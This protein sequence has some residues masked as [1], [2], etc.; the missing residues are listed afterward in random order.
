MYFQR[1]NG[2]NGVRMN[3]LLTALRVESLKFRLAPVVWLTTLVMLVLVPLVTVGG[4]AVAHFAP[5][6]PS[7]LKAQAMMHGQ[8]WEALYSL[9]AQ[10]AG[11]V[12]A[13]GV[14]IIISWCLGR[15]FTEQTVVG[16]FAQPVPRARIALAK[17]LI[18]LGW[19]AGVSLLITG[20]VLLGGSFS[21][22]TLFGGL[23]GASKLLVLGLLVSAGMLPVAWVA[24]AGRGYM[25]GVGAV[26][27]ITIVGQ[28]A[29]ALGGG[30]WVPWTAPA[31][32]AGV[33]GPQAAAQVS[34]LQLL[35][36]VLL[37]LLSVAALLHWWQK[38][39][40]G[41]ARG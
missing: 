32:W 16:L 37:G 29:T 18:T 39:E 41:N 21:G 20:L 4:Y 35:L 11:V 6:T 22:L 19:A 8:G 34:L 1:D 9:A 3:T 15:E 14:G 7:A 38:A 36:P 33:T 40:L 13:L 12:V 28:F 31:L 2:T 30:A 25:P 26:L 10:A 24:S 5:G 27:L 17:T 23:A